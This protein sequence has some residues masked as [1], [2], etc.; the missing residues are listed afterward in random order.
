MAFTYQQGAAAVLAAGQCFRAMWHF[1]PPTAVGFYSQL[2]TGAPKKG[3][4]EPAD[5]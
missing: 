1:I 5:F 2:C 3:Q 4:Q